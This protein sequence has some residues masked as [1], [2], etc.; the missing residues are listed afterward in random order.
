MIPLALFAGCAS[1][2]PER[3]RLTAADDPSGK[4]FTGLQSDERFARL[5]E[6]TPRTI[7]QMTLPMTTDASRA[8]DDEKRALSVYVV[9]R[10]TCQELGEQF[11]RAYAPAGW[12]EETSRFQG[13]YLD[14]VADLYSGA[15]TW[16]EFNR[17]R[18]DLSGEA[19]AKLSELSRSDQQTRA[20]QAS[21]AKQEAISNYL[22][23]RSLQPPPVQLPQPSPTL[24]C[25]TQYIGATAYTSC[26]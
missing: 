25:T 26:R 22:L 10:Q 13:R 14:A 7:E 8:S 11:R 9:A 5:Y 6:K 20:Q 18:R 4:C 1:R 23:F 24:N 2:P 15:S 17:R 3:P 19:R 21:A 16:G 12:A